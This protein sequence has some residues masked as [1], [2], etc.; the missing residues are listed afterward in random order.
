MSKRGR[1]HGTFTITRRQINI[2][3]EKFREGATIK[4][5]CIAAKISPSTYFR[6][7]DA[8]PEAPDFSIL[9]YFRETVFP[10]Q[11]QYQAE[12][13]ER[14]LREHREYVFSVK[15]HPAQKAY[16]RLDAEQSGI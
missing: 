12:R 2:L 7:V 14:I 9:A 13:L 8:A 10:A 15:G 6:E 11:K 16:L 3:V 1:P 4:T 5:A